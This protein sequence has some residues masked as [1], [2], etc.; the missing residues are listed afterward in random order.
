MP[1]RSLG[2]VGL[3]LDVLAPLGDRAVPDGP[4]GALSTYRVG[5]SAA[6]RVTVGSLGDLELVADAVKV[7]GL[8]TIVMGRGSNMLVADA[9]FAGVVVLLD[10][11]DFGRVEIDGDRVC[12]GG[13]AALPTLARRS[14]EAGLTGM[15]WAVGVPGSVGGGVRMNAGGHGSEI[16]HTLA[17]ATVFDLAAPQPSRTTVTS[18][19]QLALGYRRSNL[20]DSQVVIDAAFDLG[21]GDPDSGRRK[22]AEIVRWRRENQPGGQNS[23]SVFKNPPGESA[24]RLIDLAGLKGLRVGTAAVSA[25]HANFIQADEGGSADDVAALIALVQRRV[26]ERLSVELCPEVRMVGFQS[27]G[28]V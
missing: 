6:L 27:G 4:I 18:A 15:E 3:A 25:K 21:A 5:G 16:S 19:S 7:S 1:P 22:I 2:P 8:A 23:G 17:S 20:A 12:A 26:R 9:G 11:V 13:A 10:T 24:G 14:V 28:S